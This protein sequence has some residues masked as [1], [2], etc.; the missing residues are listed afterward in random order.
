M[1]QHAVDD[2]QHEIDDARRIA[3]GD[4][5]TRD[6]GAQIRDERIARGHHDAAL[7][8]EQLG[9]VAP[10]D[11]PQLEQAADQVR[12]LAMELQ[13]RVDHGAQAIERVRDRPGALDD[14]LRERAIHRVEHRLEHGVEVGEVEVQRRSLHPEG[15]GE[16]AHA[17]RD[18]T[19]PQHLEGGGGELGTASEVGA[20]RHT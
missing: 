10:A 4:L 11:R 6:A 20:A 2:G 13:R 3:R 1:N 7:A 8:V 18:P 9:D 19:R 5:A 15:V 17:R 12:A 16:L 14:A